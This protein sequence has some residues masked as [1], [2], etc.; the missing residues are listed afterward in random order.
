MQAKWD[1]WSLANVMGGT[2][3]LL[4][5]IVSLA[6]IGSG[7]AT[8]TMAQAQTQA[9]PAFPVTVAN[10]L[11]RKITQWDEY[12]GRFASVQAV[13]VR[14]R[15]SGFIEQLHFKDGQI[16]KAG[17][18]LFTIDKRTYEIAVESAEADVERYK[19]QVDL[20]VAEVDRITPLAKSGVATKREMDQRSTNLAA[21]RAQLLSAEAAL[22][23][24]KLN[25]E[26]TEVKAPISGRISDRKVDV[27]NLVTGGTSGTTLLT[28]I[29]SLDPIYF[30]F[31]VSESDFLRYSRLFLS[32][33]RA[34][35][36]EKSNPVRIKLADETG[37]P[38]EGKMDF[39]DNKLNVGTGTLRGRAIVANP[40]QLLQPG[41]FGRL[42][43]F[44]GEF[45][46]LLIPDTAVISD[47]ARK[48]VFTVGDDG[49]VKAA[50][51]ELGQLDEGLRVVRSGLKP[52]DR[53]VIDGLDN[54]M[55]RPG[56][57]VSPQP[58]K[59]ETVKGN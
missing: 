15:V 16:V 20:Q 2:W 3:M 34:S 23:Q 9:P 56:A 47:Q 30:E 41:L 14:P 26:W 24:A 4:R 21:A 57:K 50:A 54:P 46:V 37:W 13:E 8:A 43:L 1:P 58:G 12:S 28:D 22:K 51:V 59:I 48:I 5:V 25:L 38:H 17:D 6:L 40:K 36:R 19:S 55:V 10:P 7:I 18:L 44:G 32:G 11:A 33:E 45:D 39:V 42:E 49:I 53:V 52:T 29:A 31:E 27:G 35:S